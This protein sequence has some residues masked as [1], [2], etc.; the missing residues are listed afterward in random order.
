MRHLLSREFK[1]ESV[2]GR[3]LP[4]GGR[5]SYSARPFLAGV[6]STRHLPVEASILDDD[7]EDTRV[8]VLIGE[9]IVPAVVEERTRGRRVT[10][11]LWVGKYTGTVTT[12]PSGFQI[13]HLVPL[14]EAHESG[15]HAWTEEQRLRFAN[16]L[17]DAV[18]LIAVR[19]GANGSKGARD[20]AEWMPP[21]R[22]Y[23]CEYLESWV[24]V[25]QK[26]ELSIDPEE[27]SALREGFRVC[28]RY[29]S[30]DKLEGRH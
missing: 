20:P 28:G 18:A 8:E 5:L 22:A 1:G 30:G 27:A 16:D 2:L 4:V 26:Y 17:D 14:K 29:K 21:N 15:G 9:S 25:K 3:K 12:S 7:D 13:D 23:W 19:G 6:L 10:S 24:A 11:G